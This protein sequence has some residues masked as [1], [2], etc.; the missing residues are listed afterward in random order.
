MLVLIFPTWFCLP[1]VCM[2]V[3][4]SSLSMKVLGAGKPMLWLV[5][6]RCVDFSGLRWLSELGAKSHK[7][8]SSLSLKFFKSKPQNVNKPIHSPKVY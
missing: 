7:L 8:P 2:S 5:L 4:F 6:P 1:G 3:L